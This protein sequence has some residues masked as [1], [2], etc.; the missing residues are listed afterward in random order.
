MIQ[1]EQVS[2]RSRRETWSWLGGMISG[3]MIAV[4]TLAFASWTGW[5][6]RNGGSELI[7]PESVLKASGAA[8]TSTFAVATGAIDND[9]EGLFMLDHVTGQLNCYVMNWRNGKFTSRFSTNVV[10]DLGLQVAADKAPEYLLIA[11]EVAFPRGGA[12]AR[13]GQSIAYVVDSHTGQFAAYGIAWRREAPATGRLQADR[14]V[15][16]DR[17]LA[18][19]AAIRE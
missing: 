17:G 19:T 15:L 2:G 10:Q 9:V 18:R 1:S 13:P 16:L 3:S 12:G 6:D 5:F 11:G 4:L 7:L 14:M 8:R